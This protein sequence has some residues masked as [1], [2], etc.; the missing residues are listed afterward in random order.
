MP[1]ASLLNEFGLTPSLLPPEEGR[2][3]EDSQ[4]P[5]D[6]SQSEGLQ[7]AGERPTEGAALSSKD[8]TADEP[9]QQH[10]SDSQGQLPIQ[11]FQ[12]GDRCSVVVSREH[13]LVT[14]LAAGGRPCGWAR[15]GV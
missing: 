2:Q 4:Q 3:L 10:A 9:Q 13:V 1:S 12:T 8:H 5:K 15:G 14:S 6:A 11:Q 7:P